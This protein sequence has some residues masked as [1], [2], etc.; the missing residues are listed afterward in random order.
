MRVLPAIA[1]LF[2]AAG[3]GEFSTR[4]LYEQCG[5]V[6]DAGGEVSQ[7]DKPEEI[8]HCLEIVTV[9]MLTEKLPGAELN[10]PYVFALDSSPSRFID[11]W[12][13]PGSLP[14][15]EQNLTTAC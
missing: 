10:A 11:W 5:D 15:N 7:P 6:R 3:C 1:A 8:H 12:V 4:C 13:L 9:Q 2:V 14:P